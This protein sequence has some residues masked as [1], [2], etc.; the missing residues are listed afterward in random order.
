MRS[1]SRRDM[2]S[3]LS[4]PVPT[5]G[6]GIGPRPGG[7]SLRARIDL[8]ILLGLVRHHVEAARRVPRVGAAGALRDAGDTHVDRARARRQASSESGECEHILFCAGR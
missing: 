3:T 8:R 5:I 2:T 4:S 6:I 1:R 7:L